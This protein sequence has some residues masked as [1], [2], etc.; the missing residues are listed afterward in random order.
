M[1]NIISEVF[2]KTR[3]RDDEVT[4]ESPYKWKDQ[5]TDDYFK[6][7]RVTLFSLPG[8]FTLICST[9]QLPNFE[10]LFND[11]KSL[12]KKSKFKKCRSNG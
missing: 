4:G 3:V 5:T 2:F 7:I 9:Y 10:K 12:G 11:F 6:N 8:I 1:K